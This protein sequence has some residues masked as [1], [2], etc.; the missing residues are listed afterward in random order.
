MNNLNFIKISTLCFISVCLLAGCN[1]KP[2]KG[3]LENKVLQM[4]ADSLLKRHYPNKKPVTTGCVC[5][6]SEL[7][8]FDEKSLSIRQSNLKIPCYDLSVNDKISRQPWTK[9]LLVKDSTAAFLVMRAYIQYKNGFGIDAIV[10]HYSPKEDHIKAKHYQFYFDR[11]YRLLNYK[12]GKEE[13]W[14]VTPGNISRYNLRYE[15]DF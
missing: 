9:L 13:W 11:T 7:R 14:A 6:R 3:L 1:N 4:F 12:E 10:H 5:E 15:C 2:P 8:Y